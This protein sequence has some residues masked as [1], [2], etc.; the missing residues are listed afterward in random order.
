MNKSPLNVKATSVKYQIPLW[1]AV[2]WKSGS[3]P[4]LSIKDNMN[5]EPALH[6]HFAMRGPEVLSEALLLWPLSRVT[7]PPKPVVAQACK[8]SYSQLS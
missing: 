5:P 8:I 2:L 6:T 3:L 7:W 4:D 1:T